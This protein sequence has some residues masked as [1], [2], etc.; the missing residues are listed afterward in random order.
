MLTVACTGLS[1]LNS[2]R[3]FYLSLSSSNHS[4]LE[5]TTT[6]RSFYVKTTTKN[7]K[8]FLASL[9]THAQISSHA[10]I[11]SFFPKVAAVRRFLVFNKVTFALGSMFGCHQDSDLTSECSETFDRFSS[12]QSIFGDAHL[13]KRLKESFT[14]LFSFN[15]HALLG[16]VRVFTRIINET[17]F[18]AFFNNKSGI[19]QFFP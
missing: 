6:N 13:F 3:T 1:F 19:F 11:F 7:G 14:Q 9:Q 8:L 18:C 4:V 12:Q 16:I 17:K 2:C 5:H 10:L 15:L